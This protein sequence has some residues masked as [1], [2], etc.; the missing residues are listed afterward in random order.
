MEGEQADRHSIREGGQADNHGGWKENRL[1][2]M[3]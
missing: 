3:V 1:T 2:D